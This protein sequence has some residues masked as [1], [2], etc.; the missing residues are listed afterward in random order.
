MILSD[1]WHRYLYCGDS[2]VS[3]R[4][5]SQWPYDVPHV[6]APLFSGQ[7]L[8]RGD[9]NNDLR[10]FERLA[11]KTFDGVAYKI[12]AAFGGDHYRYRH[13][14]YMRGNGMHLSGRSILLWARLVSQRLER[15]LSPSESWY[16]RQRTSRVEFCSHDFE[17]APAKEI[18]ELA[19]MQ[20][21]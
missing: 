15:R 17:N 19:A 2:L 1:L 12:R 14:H 20:S 10:W 7:V 4:V 6:I 21:A 9:D 13:T 18:R 16:R 11:L 8:D 3:L 5:L